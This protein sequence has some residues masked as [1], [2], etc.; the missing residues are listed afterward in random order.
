ML[1]LGRDLARAL[2]VEREVTLTQIEG[3]LAFQAPGMALALLGDRV[4]VI[5]WNRAPRELRTMEEQVTRRLGD[6]FPIEDM[7]AVAAPGAAG[8]A[9]KAQERE[10]DRIVPDSVEPEHRHELEDGATT[11]APPVDY[12]FGPGL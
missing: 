3:G 11:P 9:V 12:D 1:R 8:R 6:A 7:R 5:H 10:A 2:G 4:L